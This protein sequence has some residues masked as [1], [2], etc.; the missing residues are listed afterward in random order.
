MAHAFGLQT[1]VLAGCLGALLC[2]CYG[3]PGDRPVSEVVAAQCAQVRSIG[4]VI[5]V[6]DAFVAAVGRGDRIGADALAD[7]AQE[8]WFDVQAGFPF[9]PESSPP[10]EFWERQRRIADA[11]PRIEWFAAVMAAMPPEDAAAG[12]SRMLPEMRALLERIG[13]PECAVIEMPPAG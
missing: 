12:I 13:Y 4:S 3:G 5:A 6:G 8:L 11:R 2:G 9:G 1:V 10:T 7:R